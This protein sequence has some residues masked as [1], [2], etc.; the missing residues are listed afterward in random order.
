MILIDR[1]R[2]REKVI[3]QQTATL[4]TSPSSRQSFDL[5]YPLLNIA[6]TLMLVSLVVYLLWQPAAAH[7]GCL[8]V[9]FDRPVKDVEYGLLL[10][11]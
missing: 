10:A 11:I 2:A 3:S 5:I 9:R 8:G 1:R 7:L 4:N 6:S